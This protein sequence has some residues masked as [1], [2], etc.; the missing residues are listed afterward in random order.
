MN[1]A[2]SWICLNTN[3]S[4]LNQIRI[5]NKQ[6]KRSYLCWRWW[7]RTHLESPDCKKRRRRDENVRGILTEPP[8]FLSLSLFA[9]EKNKIKNL[10]QLD[11]NRFVF[12]RFGTDLK[13]AWY[14]TKSAAEDQTGV[15][16]SVRMYDEPAPL[17]EDH[18]LDFFFFNC[19]YKWE[20]KEMLKGRNDF[21]FNGLDAERNSRRRWWSLKV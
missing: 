9:N 3:R 11:N 16:R 12:V 2:R 19:K 1:K 4:T 21:F 10:N 14:P 18:T 15:L 20:K 5:G 7:G 8:F 6:T 13:V 17:E